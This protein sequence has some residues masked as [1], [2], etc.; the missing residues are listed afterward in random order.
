MLDIKNFSVSVENKNILNNVNFTFYPSTVNYLFGK[1]GAGKSSLVMSLIGHPSYQV[2]G[3]VMLEQEDITQMSVCN[4]ALSGLF[5]TFQYPH[6]LPGITIEDFFY[7][8]FR[9]LNN[10]S[11]NAVTKQLFLSEFENIAKLVDFNEPITRTLEGFSGGQRKRLE[12]IQV[13]LSRPKCLIFDEIDSGM[14]LDGK[15]AIL[16]VIKYCRKIN[17]QIIII[18]IT[19]DFKNMFYEPDSFCFLS[20]GQISQISATELNN[21]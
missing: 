9:A 11:D 7:E 10:L 4:R 6:D 19:H 1:N 2:A 8:S 15:N 16:Q 3:Q 14:D 17:S 13:C 20:E 5:V 21:I 18:I 12:L